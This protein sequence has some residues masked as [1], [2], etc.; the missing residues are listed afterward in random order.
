MSVSSVNSYAK[1]MPLPSTN[2]LIFVPDLDL[3]VP[4]LKLF[5]DSF[6]L[7]KQYYSFNYQNIHFVALSTEIPLGVG[8]E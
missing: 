3:S 7:T 6:N 8:T 1:G 5:M 2:K 4:N